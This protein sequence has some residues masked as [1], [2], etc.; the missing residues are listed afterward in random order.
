MSGV[1]CPSKVE[2]TQPAGDLKADVAPEYPFGFFYS[3]NALSARPPCSGGE[4]GE[5]PAHP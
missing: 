2:Y 3:H 5:A 1:S 4:V